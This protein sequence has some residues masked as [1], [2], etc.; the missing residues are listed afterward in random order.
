[1]SRNF[2]FS[3]IL[4]C[5]TSISN[6]L[7]AQESNLQWTHFRGSNLDGISG[8]KGFPVSW[9]DSTNITW[10]TT[11]DG[12][13]WSSPVVYGNQIWITTEENREMRAICVD[14]ATG[15]IIHNRV[16]FNPEKLFRKHSINTYATPTSAIEK[17][18]VYIHFGRYGTACLDSQNGETVW[19][20]TDMQC[21]HVQG[22][23]S[24]L[25][26]YQDMLI[27]HIE[28]TDVQYIAA[29]D[30]KTGETLWKTER[31]K[32]LYDPLPNIGKKAYTTPLIV[33]VDGRDLMISNGS[34]VC[35]A[36]DPQT[37][38]EVWRIVQGEDS[39]IAMPV[40]C[41]GMVYFYTSFVSGENRERWCDLM[42]VDPGGKGD[43]R[44]THLRW[45]LKSPI[46]QLSTPVAV[47]GMLYTVDSEALL[48]CLDA[49]TGV[50]IWSEQL[51]GKYHSSPLYADGYIYISSTK[52]ETRI[53]EAGRAYKVV[54]E[55]S[56]DGEIWATPALV[57]GSIILRTDNSL[58]RIEAP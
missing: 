24:S 4:I 54:S 23:G 21:E 8:E 17:E 27:V 16:V 18:F 5:L 58:Y 6:L 3:L 32:D 44:N 14:F 29:L 20:R 47:D 31:P 26:L 40:E 42:A 19:K 45:K 7:P 9:N 12:K 2:I 50:T 28:G 22:P 55:N 30:K 41:N 33:N 39:T 51:K 48:S 10:K 34:A 36:Y 46:L 57:N 53:I 25:M 1:M 38:E 43:V 49:K 52:G 15:K 35:I 13:G 37:G 11:I 56:L